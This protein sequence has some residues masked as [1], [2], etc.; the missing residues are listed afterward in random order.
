MVRVSRM[1]SILVSARSA[2]AIDPAFDR[3][4]V[5]HLQ[6]G[7]LSMESAGSGPLSSIRASMSETY[8]AAPASGGTL[9]GV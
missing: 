5:E 6:R 1:D 4:Q 3:G 7:L 2:A 9:I 8:G